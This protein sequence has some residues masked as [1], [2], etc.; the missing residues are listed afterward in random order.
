MD[1]SDSELLE[2]F[3]NPET[4]NYA[5]NLLVR[6]YQQ[7]LYYHIRKILISHDDTND[8]LQNVF[9]K[10]WKNLS[11]FKGESQLYTWL[12]RIATNESLTFLNQKKKR[13]GIPI[14]DVST[15]L[16]N[17]LKSDTYFNS[18]D[19]NVKLQKAVLTLPDRQRLVFNMR[20]WDNIKYEEMSQILETSVG[21]LKASYHIA[22]KKV[23]EYLKT[24]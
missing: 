16:G 1:L 17:N 2:K 10:V 23:E 24:H 21:A 3:N 7:K 9:I 22:A 20:Y 14:D 13:A 12:Y 4:Q 18:D 5:F 15:F 11:G 6:Q 19:V 8:V